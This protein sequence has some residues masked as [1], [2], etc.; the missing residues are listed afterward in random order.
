MYTIHTPRRD[1][2]AEHL[3]RLGIETQKIY[4]TPVPMQPCY[5]HLGYREEDIPVASQLARE[6]LCLPMFP[7]MTDAE[8]DRVVEAIHGFFAERSR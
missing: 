3:S 8:V 2:L 5:K 4:A 1:A 7:E 6:L